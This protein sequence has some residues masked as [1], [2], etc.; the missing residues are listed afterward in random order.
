MAHPEEKPQHEKNCSTLGCSEP[1]RSTE[2][3][4]IRNSS[5]PPT[6]IPQRRGRILQRIVAIDET[7]TRAYELEL[8]RQSNEWHHKGSPRPKKCDMN[9]LGLRPALRRKCSHILR[10]NQPFILHDNAR[11]VAGTVTELLQTCDWE[12]LQYSLYSPDMSPCDYDLFS[13]LKETLR[14]KRFPVGQ[15]IRGINRN[16]LANEQ[17]TSSPHSLPNHLLVVAETEFV[18]RHV[19]ATVCLQYV[20]ET[21]SNVQETPLTREFRDLAPGW[22]DNRTQIAYTSMKYLLGAHRYLPRF[23]LAS[24][25][26]GVTIHVGTEQKLPTVPRHSCS[27]DTS[28]FSAPLY[29]QPPQTI[30]KPPLPTTFNIPPP[31]PFL[32]FLKF[33]PFALFM[34]LL[35]LFSTSM[36]L[37]EF[38][39]LLIKER[40]APRNVQRRGEKETDKRRKVKEHNEIKWLQAVPKRGRAGKNNTG[41]IY[42][43]A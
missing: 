6:E 19:A 35:S 36:N 25:R 4:P 21:H 8:K 26:T 11:H 33:I 38:N 20:N 27:T 42:K 22:S 18:E 24:N 30:F 40:E 3:A 28:R 15:S 23:T 32:F 2:V 7:W 16:N 5:T 29:T 13:R 37:E 12:I 10:E 9:P 31:P 39:Y 34:F 14:G 43:S 41:E 17:Q 1:D